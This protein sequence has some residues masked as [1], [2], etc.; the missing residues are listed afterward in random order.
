MKI[1]TYLVS[2]D[3]RSPRWQ[4]KDKP[5]SVKPSPGRDGFWYATSD[6]LGCSKDYDSQERA[7]RSLFIDN[8]CTNI[9]VSA[10]TTLSHKNHFAHA[11]LVSE[12]ACSHEHVEA[13][14]D[15]GDGENGP[16]SWGHPAFDVYSSESH[17][18]VIDD[19]GLIVNSEVIDWDF[20]LWTDL[21]I[22]DTMRATQSGNPPHGS[23]EPQEPKLERRK[24]HDRARE[25]E[26]LV[27][28]LIGDDEVDAADLAYDEL[29]RD[30][31]RTDQQIAADVAMRI[32]YP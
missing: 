1:K 28:R 14:F 29:T 21:T 9:R 8:A 4:F 3:H 13:E 22:L 16:G 15:D 24:V 18:L 7:A 12:G 32:S 27:H 20:H 25:I 31:G 11:M 19:T 2:A 23:S 26:R 6:G 10:M 17:S 30:A 5:V